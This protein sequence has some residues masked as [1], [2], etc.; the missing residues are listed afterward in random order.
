MRWRVNS[1]RDL[2]TTICSALPASDSFAR[3]HTF[4]ESENAA[5]CPGVRSLLS[6]YFVYD[7]TPHIDSVPFLNVG[8]AAE[9]TLLT[10]FQRKTLEHIGERVHARARAVIYDAGDRADAVFVVIEGVLKSYRTLRS[11]KRA[12]N[13]FLFRH[14]IFGLAERGRYLN[15]L[16][17]VTPVTLH[18]L[19]LAELVS[20]IKRDPQLQF[21]F[22]MKVTQGLREAQ[23]RSI[24]IGRRDAIGRMAMFLMM[25]RRQHRLAVGHDYDVPLPMSRADIA[26]FLS[27]SN[28]S[29]SRAAR[30]LQKRGLV[31]FESRHLARI[32]DPSALEKLAGAV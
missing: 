32:L 1:A 27:L 14:D 17:A 23:R 20:L 31:A 7:L 5:R 3:A 16:Q 6:V 4:V 22:L 21:K 19:P 30:G 15:S 24:L 9:P 28:E 26:S 13:T 29:V 8:P 18:Q 11:G 25:M 12:M 10:D 2:E